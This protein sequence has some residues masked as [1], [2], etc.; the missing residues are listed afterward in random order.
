[1]G[2][3][4]GFDFLWDIPKSIRP[5]GIPREQKGL[6]YQKCPFLFLYTERGKGPHMASWVALS[7]AADAAGRGGWQVSKSAT[8]S[9]ECYNWLLSSKLT[10]FPNLNKPLAFPLH[11]TL[12]TLPAHL[13]CTWHWGLE[14]E[15]S[16]PSC[17]SFWMSAL[18]LRMEGSQTQSRL[19]GAS[20]RAFKVLG[21]KPAS[22]L[23]C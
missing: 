7:V 18:P 16:D 12:H 23:P 8:S 1:M 6:F 4:M 15:Q 20:I 22:K 3:A 21:P 5:P 13:L 14:G 10:S 2:W 17:W 9:D 11:L 19:Q